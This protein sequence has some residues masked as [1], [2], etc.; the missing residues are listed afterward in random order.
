[1]AVLRGLVTVEETKRDVKKGLETGFP[2]GGFMLSYE[3]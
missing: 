3:T 1:M 2:K